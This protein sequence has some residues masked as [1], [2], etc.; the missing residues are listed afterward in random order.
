MILCVSIAEGGNAQAEKKQ[1]DDGVFGGVIDAGYIHIRVLFDNY[2]LVEDMEPSWGFACIV[3]T[4]DD[5]ILFDTGGDGEILLD[6]MKK[7]AIDPE[8]IKYVFLS[9]WHWDHAG[10]LE[11]MLDKNNNV[12]VFMPKSF[13]GIIKNTV[14]ESG[15]RLAEISDPAQVCPGVASSGEFGGWIEEQALFIN[16][17]KGVIVLTGC[18]H[19]GIVHIVEKAAEL[20]GG[21]VLLAAG[22]FHL[23]DHD[24]EQVADI[25]TRL[26]E[27]GVRFAAP[28]HCTGESAIAAFKK[29]YGDDYLP[30][31]TGSI[32]EFIE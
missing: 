27:L 31:G 24:E 9:H 5:V 22:G 8:E 32:I 19:P 20:S 21:R 15:A 28:S 14:T 3:Y 7:T 10:G 23:R 1:E 17:N 13:P 12:T 30:L 4:G 11:K 29:S 26:K 25:I 16:T 6:N 2:A 18:A